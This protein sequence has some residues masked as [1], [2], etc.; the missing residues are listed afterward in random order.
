M[1]KKTIISLFLIIMIIGITGCGKKTDSSTTSN[2]ESSITKLSISEV[3]T[4]RDLEQT[5][6]KK[7]AKTYTVS[8]NKNINI[9]EEGVYIITGSAENASIII[10]ADDEAKV[11]L[12]LSDLTIKNNNTPCI[13]VKSADKVFVTT[14][15]KNNLTVSDTFT[16]DGT[17]NTDA[18]IFSKDDLVMNGTGTLTISS[19]CK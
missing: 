13:Y 4:D 19:T 5:A 6:D 17:T 16:S 1:K 3:F 2:N 10:E 9:T 18:V 7:D 8:D 14:T 15:G 12:V 11:Q